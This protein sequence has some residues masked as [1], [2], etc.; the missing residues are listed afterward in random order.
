LAGATH[1]DHALLPALGAYGLHLGRAFQMVDDV[2]D[3]EGDPRALGK[4]V[5][6][7][8]REGKLTLPVLIALERE[9]ELRARLDACVASDGDEAAG[10][11]EIV[12]RTGAAHA[13]RASAQRE[14]ARAVAALDP[15]PS[16]PFKEA[17]GLIAHELCARVS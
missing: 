5:M 17:L 3:V 2:L 13:A 8:L 12:A 11:A 1:A 15:V 4:S 9:P 10:V 16:S 14:T 7:D 6:A